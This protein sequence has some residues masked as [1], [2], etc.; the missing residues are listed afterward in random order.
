M[1]GEFEAGGRW[2]AN[3]E[4]CPNGM[5][6]QTGGPDAGAP[7]TSVPD[8]CVHGT[9]VAGIAL[10]DGGEGA[11]TGV[12]PEAQLVSVRVG[13]MAL[14]LL[15]VPC[16]VINDS[17]LLAAMQYVHDQKRANVPTIDVVNLSL[18]KPS[19]DTP[20]PA[21]ALRPAVQLLRNDNIAVVV[22]SGNDDLQGAMSE[23]ACIPEAT[24]VGATDD[25][26]AVADFSNLAESTTL[27]AP[28]VNI[29]SSVPGGG[30]RNAN[31]T[32]MAAPHVAGA[33]ALMRGVC[34]DLGVSSME[35]VLEFGGRDVQRTVDGTTIRRR[36]IDVERVLPW[37]GFCP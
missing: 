15:I 6:S 10:G 11:M 14:C 21:S 5:L 33:M 29:N 4:T 36:R 23:P 18:G 28:G 25:T 17:S 8:A 37:L 2:F 3:G 30:F 19:A 22:S 16:L 24:S 9:H 7:C 27:M 32:S 35:N 13:E 20:C 34:R 26:D 12:A 31:G 1:R